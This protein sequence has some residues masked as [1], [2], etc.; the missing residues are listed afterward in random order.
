[1]N[2]RDERLGRSLK[3]P[4]LIQPVIE[5][6]GRHGGTTHFQQPQGATEFGPRNCLDLARPG[7]IEPHPLRFE[8]RRIG[9]ETGD[10]PAL[11]PVFRDIGESIRGR[12]LGNDQSVELS[13]CYQAVE[14]TTHLRR[15]IG[16][17]LGRVGE[18]SGDRSIGCVSRGAAGEEPVER[19]V[20]RQM[21][22]RSIFG[23]F[24]VAIRIGN[25]SRLAEPRASR[26]DTR[27]CRHD[28]PPRGAR[29]AQSLGQSERIGNWRLNQKRAR[30]EQKEHQASLPRQ[31][32]NS[33]PIVE[34]S[35][36]TMAMPGPARRSGCTCTSM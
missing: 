33:P 23:V 4:S 16:F 17:E 36:R 24:V 7:E 20:E 22:A 12:R 29:L 3:G 13:G 31:C 21:L 19:L 5:F 25:R 14:R 2:A 26:C 11:E 6:G 9:L 1:L 30:G 28:L 35:G 18:R 32:T 8:K 10:V 34:A 15:E 27:S